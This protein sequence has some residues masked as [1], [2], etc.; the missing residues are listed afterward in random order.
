MSDWDLFDSLEGF[1]SVGNIIHG[2]KDVGAVI[3]RS[4]SVANTDHNIFKDYESLLMLESFALHLLWAHGAF[5]VF[6]VMAVHSFS[7]VAKASIEKPV[8]TGC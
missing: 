2:V 6:A 1:C 5:A 7:I 4:A 3:S 8:E